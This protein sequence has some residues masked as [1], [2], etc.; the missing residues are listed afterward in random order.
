VSDVRIPAGRT[1]V[2]WVALYLPV[3]WP[4]GMVRTCPE[5]DPEEGGTRPGEFQADVGEVEALL[6]RLA[7][8]T[9]ES[10]WPRHPVFGAMSR[11]AWLRW[12]YLHLDHHLRQFGA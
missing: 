12:G 11:E 6:E 5:L 10:A 4:S 8:R 7:G 1:V 3:R 2:K 9:D